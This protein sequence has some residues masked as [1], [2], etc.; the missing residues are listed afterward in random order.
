MKKATQISIL[1]ILFVSI[2]MIFLVS[3]IK[4]TVTTTEK[5]NQLKESKTGNW[6]TSTIAEADTYIDSNNG[7]SNYG[8]QTWLY[9]GKGVLDNLYEAYFRFNFSDKPND[10]SKA[11]ISLNFWSIDQTMDIEIYLINKTWEEFS[12]TW[13]NKP[14]HDQLID[15]LTLTT[16]KRYE[17]D[18]TNF[19]D[20]AATNISICVSYNIFISDYVLIDSREAGLGYSW[21]GEDNPKLIWTYETELGFEIT[22]PDSS[23]DLKPGTHN[24]LWGSV[25]GGTH[26]K[27]D[28][29]KGNSHVETITQ[30]TSNDGMYPWSIYKYDNFDGTDYRIKLTDYD[31][32]EIDGFSDYFEISIYDNYW[33][34][35]STPS[36]GDTFMNGENEITWTSHAE[37]E[38]IVIALYKD[39]SYVETITTMTQND[40]SYWWTIYDS[41]GF[42]GTDYCMGIFDYYHT[43]VNDISDYFEISIVKDDLPISSIPSYPVGLMLV[44]IL[45]T[46]SLI[47]FKDFQKIRK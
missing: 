32:N 23:D 12:M 35:I 42:D 13:M 14:S 38:Y 25:G 19:I 24:I 6:T 37:I 28:L 43:S 22:Q 47:L 8:G 16:D 3:E 27:I 41:D 29:Y 15:T 31:D 18:V 39:E 21:Y 2:G 5:T 40:G 7:M 46:I 26:V 17:I 4:F 34:S 45:T 36:S 11:T 10:W 20:P 30:Q 44:S 33:I 1:L 9:A